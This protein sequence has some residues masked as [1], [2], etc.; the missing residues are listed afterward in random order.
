M[1]GD[2]MASGGHATAAPCNSSEARSRIRPRSLSF[3]RNAQL[4]CAFSG[5]RE[6][7]ESPAEASIADRAHDTLDFEPRIVASDLRFFVGDG[8]MVKASDTTSE[9]GGGF[10]A[11]EDKVP[12]NSFAVRAI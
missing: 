1:P 5:P 12:A 9:R 3:A 6:R 11:K 10:P 2:R 7:V 8:A 4:N